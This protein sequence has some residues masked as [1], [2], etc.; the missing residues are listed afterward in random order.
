MKTN[1]IIFIMGILSFLGCS[2]KNNLSK[3]ETEILTKLNFEKDLILELKNE[4]HKIILQLPAIDHET[5]D[6]LESEK[7]DGIYSESDEENAEVIV[8]K[9]KSEFREKGYLIFYFEGNKGKKNV[10]VLKGNDELDILRYIRTDGINYDL[11]SKDVLKKISE[12]KTK[13]GLIIIGCSQDYVHIEFEKLPSNMDEFAK[14]V[15]AFCPDS[16]EQGVG[17]LKSLKEYIEKEKGIWLWWD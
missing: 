11:E 16:V 13:Y 10:G 8:R 12:W 14:E 5:G 9:L 15:Y 3:S 7:F 2:N 4:T 17:D 6:M 1:L